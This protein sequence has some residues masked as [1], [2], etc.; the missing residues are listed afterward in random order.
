GLLAALGL[1]HSALWA[2][3]A[4]WRLLPVLAPRAL[5]AGLACLATIV[6]VRAIRA[7]GLLRSGAA[8]VVAHAVAERVPLQLQD[9]LQLAADVLHDAAHVVLVQALAAHLPEALE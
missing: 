6:A 7:L 3:W 2:L 5:L 9:L 1:R 8:L 4:L